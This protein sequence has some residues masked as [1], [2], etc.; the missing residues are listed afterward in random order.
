MLNKP[1]GG[2]H[3]ITPKVEKLLE[4]EISA[5]TT[6]PLPST[7]AATGILFPLR[8]ASL[9]FPSFPGQRDAPRNL[10]QCCSPF[11]FASPSAEASAPASRIRG[12]DNRVTNG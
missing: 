7:A 1:W 12:W 9:P 3:T 6:L 10:R 8:P 11:Q 2:L 4:R 5:T